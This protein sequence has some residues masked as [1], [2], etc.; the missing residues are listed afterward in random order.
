MQ[1]IIDNPQRF[2]GVEMAKISGPDAVSSR[3][4]N[5]VICTSGG[6]ATQ[7]VLDEILRIQTSQPDAF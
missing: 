5:I 4:E 6:D 7:R 3:A 1:S 2:P